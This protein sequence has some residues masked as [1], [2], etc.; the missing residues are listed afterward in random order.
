MLG[1][2]AFERHAEDRS[3][4]DNASGRGVGWA[5]RGRSSGGAGKGAG[6]AVRDGV[7]HKGCWY[8]VSR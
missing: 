2:G 3:G 7:R 4:V 1:H 6:D 5:E 8:R